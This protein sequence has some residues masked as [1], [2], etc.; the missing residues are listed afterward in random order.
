MKRFYGRK[1]YKRIKKIN[2]YIIT[3]IFV[4]VF[5]IILFNVFVEKLGYNI[6]YTAKIKIEELTK[7]HLNQTVKKFLNVDTSDY[8]NINLVNNNIVSVDIN[9]NKSN[10]LLQNIIKD[11]E[12]NIYD[13]EKG[14]I[15]EYHNLEMLRADNGVVVFMPIGVV[16]NNSLFSRLGPRIPVK[17]SFLENLSAYVD[18]DVENY[19]INNSLIKLYIN[20]EVE[21]IVELPIEKDRNIV[22]YKFLIASKLINGKV[23]SVLGGMVDGTSNIVNS[24]VN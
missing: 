3:C 1:K 24:S 11:V 23:P 4:F 14:K 8:I 20:I 21:E 18:V 5:D 13:I 19:G 7:Y 22:K 12:K 16:L 15:K 17:V 2:K 6:S 9:N 10:L